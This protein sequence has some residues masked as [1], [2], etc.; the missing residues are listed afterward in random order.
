MG[1]SIKMNRNGVILPGFIITVVLAI[2]IAGTIV[3]TSC[4]AGQEAPATQNAPVKNQETPSS[5]NKTETITAKTEPPQEG[6]SAPVPEITVI[7]PVTPA[8]TPV[9]IPV[10]P[11]V[12][13][14]ILPNITLITPPKVQED[15]A[16]K[17]PTWN[18]VKDFL[19]SDNTD[20]HP[21][22]SPTFVNKNFAE[23]LQNNAKKAGWRCAIVGVHLNWLDRR[24][25]D[26]LSVVWFLNAFETSD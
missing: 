16:L 20:K 15:A 24:T 1:K 13:A 8:P 3:V 9:P 11:V 18:E 6:V 5:Q 12:P 10:S 23:T 21:Y 26:R 2:F 17:N 25:G 14:S 7:T 4:S 22:V 19:L